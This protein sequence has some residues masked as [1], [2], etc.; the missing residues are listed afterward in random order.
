M[1]KKRK[2][3]RTTVN[4]PEV[5]SRF[6]IRSKSLFLTY[7]K[8]LDIPN[9][10][11][12]FIESL[13]DSIGNSGS[14]VK[15]V[16]GKENHADGTPH[17]HVYLEYESIQ[18]INSRKQLEVKL[19]N[20]STG[21]EVIQVGKYEPVKN[22][23]K[24]IAYIIKDM[25]LGT[26]EIPLKN[27]NMMLPIVDFV[28]YDSPE[29]HLVAVLEKEGLGGALSTLASCYK[30][31]IIKKGT[32]IVSNLKLLDDLKQKILSKSLERIHDLSEFKNVPV[33]IIEWGRQEPPTTS[34]IIH[35]P[36]NTGKTE[37]AKTIIKSMGRELIFC[38]DRNSLRN[39][40]I[41]TGLSGIVYDDVHLNDL[42]RE[43]I[44]HMLDVENTSH[45]RVLY[46]VVTIPAGIPRIFTTNDA[47]RVLR[48]GYSMKVPK[49]IMRRVTLVNVKES[50][51]LNVNFVN[52]TI[53]NSPQTKI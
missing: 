3:V 18:Y 11:E 36:S 9:L 23:H 35:G 41:R 1:E 27:T 12:L 21:E 34:L 17:I 19:V 31:L 52:V 30:K 46:G 8:V 22:K 53:N 37:L 6:R 29:D 39:E 43:E 38:R 47:N 51:Q 2:T 10:E 5:E 40:S 26:G 44:I 24:V 28:Y 4:K 48:P 25:D 45:I 42:S 14:D 49:E 32:T 13:K 15:Y 50:L 16:I 20:P 7:P 33:E